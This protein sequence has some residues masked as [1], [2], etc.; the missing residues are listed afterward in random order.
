M[1][2]KKSYNNGYVCICGIGRGG[3]GGSIVCE[4]G[5]TV[6]TGCVCVTN[7]VIGNVCDNIR[8]GKGDGNGCEMGGTVKTG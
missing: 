4:F 8:G 5:D 7:G 1:T 3:N 6:K 2:F